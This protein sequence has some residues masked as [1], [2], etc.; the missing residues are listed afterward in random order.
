MDIERITVI[1]ELFT[2]ESNGDEYFHLINLAM[3]ETGVML[4][5]DEYRTD[6]RLNYLAAAIAYYRLQQL[7][8]ARE[9]AAY[10]YGGRVLKKSQNTAYEYSKELLRDYIQICSDIIKPQNFVFCSFSGKEEEI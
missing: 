9:R 1:F 8:A 10:T 5:S 7:L 2:G 6:Y 3:Y 4:R